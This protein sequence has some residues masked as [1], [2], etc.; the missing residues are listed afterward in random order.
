MSVIGR[1]FI[2]TKSPIIT[3]LYRFILP[4]FMGIEGVGL[5]I[6]LAVIVASPL[7]V[8]HFL[9]APNIDGFFNDLSFYNPDD[10]SSH[11]LYWFFFWGI[12]FSAIRLGSSVVKTG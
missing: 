4:Y 6:L 3:F 11:Y 2:E 9:I 1:E 7:L 12:A 5:V 10:M 8:F